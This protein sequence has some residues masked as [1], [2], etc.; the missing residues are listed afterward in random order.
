M[1]K[2]TLDN[3]ALE[4]LNN[5]IND[6]RDVLNEVCCTDSNYEE[7]EERLAISRDLDELIIKYMN[8][9]GK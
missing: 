2:M 3:I 5:R 7:Q 8:E 4:K 6:L 1:E 9:L